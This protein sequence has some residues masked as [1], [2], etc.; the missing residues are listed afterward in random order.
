[1]NK[2]VV[3]T[4]FECSNGHRF[5][6]RSSWQCFCGYMAYP[7]E[8]VAATERVP[9]LETDEGCVTVERR[10]AGNSRVISAEERKALNQKKSRR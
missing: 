5:A 1:L 3:V 7:Q 8:M 4:E 2:Y 6:E 10:P 9:I